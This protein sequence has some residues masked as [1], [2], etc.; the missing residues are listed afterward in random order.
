MFPD[1]LQDGSLLAAALRKRT[2][3]LNGR[4]HAHTP[5]T[6]GFPKAQ[7]ARVLSSFK[8]LFSSIPSSDQ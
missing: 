1:C 4:M 2:H 8:L 7:H 3:T 6:G 5:R